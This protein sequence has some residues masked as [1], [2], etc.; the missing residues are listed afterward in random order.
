MIHDYYLSKSISSPDQD[1]VIPTDQPTNCWANRLRF[2]GWK[3][4]NDLLIGSLT[5]R[6]RIWFPDWLQTWRIQQWW[7]WQLTTPASGTSVLPVAKDPLPKGRR[8]EAD[9]PVLVALTRWNWCLQLPPQPWYLERT[10]PWLTWKC[11]CIQQPVLSPLPTQSS[12]TAPV[13]IWFSTCQVQYTNR[14]NNCISFVFWAF[15][16]MTATYMTYH[17][18]V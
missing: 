7:R 13:L 18:I 10:A 14:F 9:P 5:S 8:L 3:N 15:G 1:C 2:H 17:I 12:Q 11:S 16:C 6:G 4:Q